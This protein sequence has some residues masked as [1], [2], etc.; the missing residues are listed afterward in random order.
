MKCRYVANLRD[1]SNF[2][3]LPGNVPSLIQNPTGVLLGSPES[4]VRRKTVTASRLWH[5]VIGQPP[6][7][8]GILRSRRKKWEQG[9]KQEG[10]KGTEERGELS[11]AKN[12][13]VQNWRGGKAE[14]MLSAT[15][16][17]GQR[18]PACVTENE[19][20]D[21]TL[22]A[23][24]AL[25]GTLSLHIPVFNMQ[26]LRKWINECTDL[27]LS[28]SAEVLKDSCWLSASVNPHYILALTRDP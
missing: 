22:H 3:V 26:K 11:I 7:N 28:P 1:A 21:T 23:V 5:S 24:S 27:T 12:A 18:V 2:Q 17:Q 14:F 4:T 6:P 19:D 13:E 16:H 10:Q 8:K 25:R 20:T 9:E 15:G